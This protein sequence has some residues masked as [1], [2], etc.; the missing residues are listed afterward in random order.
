MRTDPSVNSWSLLFRAG[1]VSG[2]AFIIMI[3]VPLV[4]LAV[5]P[6]P[7]TAGGVAILEY[8]AAHRAIYLAELVCFVGLSL[9]ALVVFLALGAALAPLGKSLAVMGAVIGAG[10]ELIALALGSSPPSLTAG[11][12]VLS[13]KYAAAGEA[14]RPSLASAAEALMAYANAVSSA[15]M[16]TALGILLL[17]IPMT[18]G[19]FPK[20]AAFLGIATGAAGILCEA[21]RDLIGMAYA[22][23]G[24]LL[25]TWFALVAY[26]L[27]KM[28]REATAGR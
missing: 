13:D 16:L 3:I 4:L 14:L 2:L 20:G 19:V 5:A 9:P 27:A 22:V 17:S 23:Y 12:V 18:R 10:S 11:L 28:G 21:F 6:Q 1:A 24:L 25:P 15:G 7:P 26:R 8:V